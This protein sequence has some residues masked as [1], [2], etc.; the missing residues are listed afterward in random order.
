MPEIDAT[1]SDFACPGA[2][3]QADARSLPFPGKHFDMLTAF[4]MLEH[5]REDD[6]P[7]VLAEFSR[8]SRQF[9]FSISHAPSVNKWNGE[10]L[11]PTV[12]PESW[13]MMQLMR[14]GAIGLAKH[15]RYITG[16]WMPLPKIAPHETVVLVGNGPSVL[17]RELGSTIDGFKHIVRF[18]NFKI[19]GFERHVGRRISFWSTFFKRIDNPLSF[20]RVICIHEGD[21]PPSGIVESFHLPSMFYNTIRSDVQRRAAWASGFQRDA[22]PLLASSG[23]LVASWMLDILG[24]RKI[25]LVGFDHFSKEK[26]SMHH[27]WLS[28]PYKQP[29]EHAGEVEFAMFD[30]LKRAG[31]VEML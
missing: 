2:D 13:W 28:G 11:H 12:R 31:R 17:E 27:Y 16:R 5:L 3:L 23:L 6:V 4:D 10:T 7:S 20:D 19:L 14:A 29:K 8:V 30:E 18:N 1:G 9:V 24:V 25:H 22:E 15:G 21:K 26:T